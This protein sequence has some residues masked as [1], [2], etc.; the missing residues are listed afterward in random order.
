MGTDGHETSEILVTLIRL[1][2]SAS[3]DISLLEHN[4]IPFIFSAESQMRVRLINKS[5]IRP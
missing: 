2:K 4:K 5:L 1:D 3:P